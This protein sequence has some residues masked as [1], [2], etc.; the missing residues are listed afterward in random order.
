MGD[1]IEDDFT[2]LFLQIIILFLSAERQTVRA[3]TENRGRLNKYKLA[4]K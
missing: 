3:E 1:R 2:S 4:V